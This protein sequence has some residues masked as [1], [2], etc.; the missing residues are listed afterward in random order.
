MAT[1]K[2]VAREVGCSVTTVSR[3]LNGHDDV[4]EATGQRIQEVARQLDYYPN[5]VARSLQNQR[6]GAIGLLVPRIL[7]RTY[8]TFWLEFIGGMASACS[9]HGIDLVLSA[10]ESHPGTSAGFLRLVRSGR[11]DGV[12]ICDVLRSDPRVG[13]LQKHRMPFVAFGRTRSEQGYPYIDVDGAAGV[14]MAVDRLAAYGHR[15]I[16]FLG[17]DPDFGF[18]YFRLAGFRNAMVQHRLPV[19]DED[20]CEGLSESTAPERIARL[21]T[22][23]ERPTA[24]VAAADFLAMAAL[25]E[26]H[27]LEL[28][29]PGDLSLVVFDDNS[30][31]QHTDPPLTAISQPNRRLGEEVAGMLLDRLSA[32]DGPVV[33]R[34]VVPTL[35]NRES[36]ARL[37]VIDLATAAG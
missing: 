33:Q 17:L 27:A 35:I 12:V 30:M 36:V 3:A 23:V 24:L 31:V 16:A 29:V 8:D 20:I 14:G 25:R 2:D 21:L 6:A 15:R 13:Y 10:I 19:R 1:I 4:S 37:T 5:A 7:H 22:G 11:V 32:P 28:A 34:L 9:A 18:S 26:A